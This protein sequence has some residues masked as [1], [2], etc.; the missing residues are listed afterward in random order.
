MQYPYD[1]VRTFMSAELEA[2]SDEVN[3]DRHA[4]LGAQLKARSLEPVEVKG[5]YKGRP[6]RAYTIR[7]HPGQ[8]M[9]I[10]DLASRYGQESVLVVDQYLHAKLVFIG[11]DRT[12]TEIGAGLFLPTS[13]PHAEL[14]GYTVMPDGS[15]W[16]LVGKP[17]DIEAAMLPR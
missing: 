3:A 1:R 13:K 12:T 11:S 7:H 16:T 4:N 10:T 5:C 9:Y 8:L 2:Y 15:T 6:E 14:V 17:F